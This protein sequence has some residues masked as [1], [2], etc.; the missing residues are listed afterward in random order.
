[1]HTRCNFGRSKLDLSKKLLTVPKSLWIKKIFPTFD[2]SLQNVSIVGKLLHYWL[3]HWVAWRCFGKSG[4]Q[5][6]GRYG[7]GWWGILSLSFFFNQYFA[8]FSHSRFGEIVLKCVGISMKA[9]AK[10]PFDICLK[11]NGIITLRRPLTWPWFWLSNHCWR[12]NGMKFSIWKLDMKW[13]WG[14]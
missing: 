12:A 6:L 7:H 11:W 2:L 9:Y 4:H 1:M 3:V 10:P 8:I 13:D 14:N 5:I